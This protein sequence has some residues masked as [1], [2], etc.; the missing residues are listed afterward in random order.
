MPEETTSTMESTLRE[1]RHRARN[2]HSAEEKVRIILEGIHQN[3]I[4]RGAKNF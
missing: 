1:N 4:I 3:C 2:K